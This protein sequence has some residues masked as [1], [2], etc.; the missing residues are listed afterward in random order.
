[1]LSNVVDVSIDI[2]ISTVL[3]MYGNGKMSTDEDINGNVNDRRR[4]VFFNF[5][6]LCL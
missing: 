4:Y 3:D 5:S 1:M 2:F 6:I